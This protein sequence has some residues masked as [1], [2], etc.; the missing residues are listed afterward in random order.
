MGAGA[1]ARVNRLAR[2][3]IISNRSRRGKNFS[4]AAAGR[5]GASASS[6]TR[7]GGGRSIPGKGRTFVSRQGNGTFRRTVNDKGVPFITASDGTKI[8][9]EFGAIVK[10][11]KGD[12]KQINARLINNR[13]GV[14]E[15]RTNITR[16]ADL[17]TGQQRRDYFDNSYIRLDSETAFLRQQYDV[18]PRNSVQSRMIDNR[19]KGNVN[20]MNH[21]ERQAGV[22]DGLYSPPKSDGRKRIR[23]FGGSLL[24]ALYKPEYNPGRKG[25]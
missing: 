8:K 2:E 22:R 18:Y 20:L 9:G 24:D 12:F 3:M 15:A 17:L 4:L 16:T 21:I 1:I 25:I 6:G 13:V 11:Q 23:D 7:V 14:K 19:I 10:R 5:V